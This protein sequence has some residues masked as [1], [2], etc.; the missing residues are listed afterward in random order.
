M[1]ATSIYR[2]RLC[3]T[4]CVLYTPLWAIQSLYYIAEEKFIN[5]I[6]V[7]LKQFVE[8]SLICKLPR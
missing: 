8:S 5:E 4:D 1:I 3:H 2:G 7:I 6:E